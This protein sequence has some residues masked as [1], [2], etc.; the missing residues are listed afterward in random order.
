MFPVAQ[1]HELT[2]IVSIVSIF[3]TRTLYGIACPSSKPHPAA[4][5]LICRSRCG[6]YLSSMTTLL[7]HL[8][9]LLPF[10]FGG[11]RQLALENL[12][13]RQQLAVYKRMMARP[14]LHGVDRIFWVGLARMW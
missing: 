5:W 14:R 4:K 3:R 12:A 10:I 2:E 11:H 7:L 13:L 9:R 6:H 8:L 1:A